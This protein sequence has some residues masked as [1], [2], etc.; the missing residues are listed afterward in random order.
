MLSRVERSQGEPKLYS[1]APP[2]PSRQQVGSL[3][4]VSGPALRSSTQRITSRIRTK[5]LINRH[6]P[7]PPTDGRSP[8]S[9]TQSVGSPTVS[10]SPMSDRSPVTPARLDSNRV[11]SGIEIWD[12]NALAR[13]RASRILANGDKKDGV[14]PTKPPTT[15]ESKS[16]RVLLSHRESRMSIADGAT[17][18][19]TALES[20]SSRAHLSH[21]ESRMSISKS[22]RHP[23]SPHSS[24]PEP[25]TPSTTDSS[26]GGGAFLTRKP[27]GPFQTGYSE[28][29]TP[30]R[31]STPSSMTHASTAATST[32]VTLVTPASS[33]PNLSS[34]DSKAQP[35][36][37]FRRNV[38]D[39]FKSK[40]GM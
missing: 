36:S 5:D 12:E 37:W 28:T 31:S 10:R 3:D 30:P 35:K 24:A 19:P 17:K 32:Q 20:K 14:H 6:K 9:A 15:L 39:P 13:R 34:L 25:P 21:R 40:L 27:Q 4:V 18:P 33:F 29:S 11:D 2:V 26:R 16:S 22:H 7:L 23:P 38:L 1:T 8:S